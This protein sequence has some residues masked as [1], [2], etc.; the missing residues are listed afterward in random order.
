M[1]TRALA[2]LRTQRVKSELQKGRFACAT[3]RATGDPHV[4]GAVEPKPP[5]LCI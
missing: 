4:S 2:T 1:H 5:S 3:V